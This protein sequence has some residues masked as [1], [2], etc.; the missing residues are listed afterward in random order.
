MLGDMV[1]KALGSIGITK[2]RV[3]AWVGSPC[4]CKERQDKLNMLGA[5]AR[6][7]IKNKMKNSIRFLEKLIGKEL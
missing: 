4:G 2:E 5:W 1:E 7:T 3:E 6:M